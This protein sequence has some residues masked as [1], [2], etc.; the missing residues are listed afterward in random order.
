MKRNMVSLALNI[1]QKM[2]MCRLRRNNLKSRKKTLQLSS[3]KNRS[4]LN[5]KNKKIFLKKNK[6]ILNNKI[7]QQRR[8]SKCQKS[9]KR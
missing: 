1:Q 3:R 4:L 7:Q 2:Y 8:L 5:K 9:K 6:K